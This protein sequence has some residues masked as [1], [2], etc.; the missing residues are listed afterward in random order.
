M[1]NLLSNAAKFVP[2]GSGRVDVTLSCDGG[3]CAS[4]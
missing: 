4:R 3:A 2:T 1:L